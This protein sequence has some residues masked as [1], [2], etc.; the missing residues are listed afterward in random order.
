MRRVSLRWIAIGLFVGWLGLLATSHGVLI[1]S[2][3]RQPQTAGGQKGYRL[4]V[5]SAT[6]NQCPYGANWS[7]AGGF[8]NEDSYREASGD[9]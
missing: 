3:T 6:N 7:N 9:D 2:E 8:T 1:W 4:L 5:A